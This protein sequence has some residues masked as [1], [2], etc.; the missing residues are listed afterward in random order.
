MIYS[1]QRCAWYTGSNTHTLVDLNH[2]TKCVFCNSY[3]TL[4]KSLG[5][6][7]ADMTGLC[8]GEILY[9]SCFVVVRGVGWILEVREARIE[10]TLRYMEGSYFF[11]CPSHYLGRAIPLTFFSAGS[12]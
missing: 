5:T 6:G 8:S 9:Y 2:G 12:Y 1:S 11:I 7:S 4:S 10:V 3:L